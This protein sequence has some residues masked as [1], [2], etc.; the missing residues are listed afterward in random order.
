MLLLIKKVI[1][2]GAIVACTALALSY[3]PTWR[4]D[5]KP[6]ETESNLLVMKPDTHYDMVMLGTSHGREFSRHSNHARAENILGK[7]FV[8]L[9]LGHGRG[10]YGARIFLDYFLRIGDGADT[11]VY[12]IDPWVFYSD[13][14]NENNDTFSEEPLNLDFLTFIIQRKADALTIINYLK[15]NISWE[16]FMKAPTPDTENTA[17]LDAIDPDAVAKRIASLYPDGLDENTFHKYEGELNKLIET[18]R[19][20]HM[21]L[22]FVIPPTLLGDMPGENALK[23]VLTK[24]GAEWHDFSNAITDPRLYFDHDHLNTK[25]I[26]TFTENYLRSLISGNPH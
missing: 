1:L 12:L 24:D 5:F 2:L 8:N 25:G 13:K 20:N 23:N 4:Y 19:T 6:G 3:I 21:R 16:Q 7:T 26:V 22:I 11:I 17:H 18:A 14:W 10:I 9:S 15:S